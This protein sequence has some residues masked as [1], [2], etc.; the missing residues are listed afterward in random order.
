MRH[1][2]DAPP[3]AADRLTEGFFATAGG[4]IGKAAQDAIRNQTQPPGGKTDSG[5]MIARGAQDAIRNQEQQAK[6]PAAPNVIGRAAADAVKNAQSAGSKSGTNGTPPSDDGPSPFDSFARRLDGVR[7]KN[8]SESAEERAA[9][10]A[11][12]P[13]DSAGQGTFVREAHSFRPSAES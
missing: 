8:E 7:K 12:Q 4:I 3:Q 11:S 2:F 1:S 5:G 13:P 6:K 9:S 10:E